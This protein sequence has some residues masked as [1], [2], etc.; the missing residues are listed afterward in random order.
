[1]KISIQWGNKEILCQLKFE[2]GF[3]Y[4]DID[5]LKALLTY[6]PFYDIWDFSFTNSLEITGDVVKY[7]KSAQ[8]AVDSM[9]NYIKCAEVYL[10]DLLSK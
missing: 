7:G 1:M 10:H 2:H 6:D 3:W 8:E 9:Y 5:E 4:G